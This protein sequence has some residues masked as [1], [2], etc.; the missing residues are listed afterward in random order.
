M[1]TTGVVSGPPIQSA[2]AAERFIR[3]NWNADFL[4]LTSTRRARPFQ[5]S[6]RLAYGR[7]ISETD[8]VLQQRDIVGIARSTV[9]HLE[10]ALKTLRDDVVATVA[11]TAG[12]AYQ[13]SH[14]HILRQHPESVAS[15][16]FSFHRDDEDD[17]RIRLTFIV[18][19]TACASSMQVFA[20]RDVF[21][22]GYESGSWAMFNSKA[23]HSSMPQRDE[24]VKVAFFFV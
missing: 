14:A 5:N 8:A 6:G 9:S 22:Y 16:S 1:L 11:R 13:L 15:S 24:C 21:H 17:S 7:T 12:A 18:K 2:S 3:E 19:L 23:F 4:E 10:G 20:A